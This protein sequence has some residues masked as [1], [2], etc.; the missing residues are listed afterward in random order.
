MTADELAACRARAEAAT[1]G[2]WTECG[3]DRG[4]C[5]C[6]MAYAE[7][8]PI[9][10]GLTRLDEEHT[11]GEGV[12]D[13][14]GRLNTRFIAH[15]REDI[16]RLLATIAARDAEIARLTCDVEGLKRANALL[17]MAAT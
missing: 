4:G 3:H 1:P 15:A 8:F 9:A 16:P 6:H 10:A 11:L 17:D 7:Q 5:L 2:P 14:Q 13:A 12:D